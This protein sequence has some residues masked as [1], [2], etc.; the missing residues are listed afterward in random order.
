DRAPALPFERWD[1][2]GATGRTCAKADCAADWDAGASNRAMLPVPISGLYDCAN[3]GDAKAAARTNAAMS[4]FMT[5]LLGGTWGQASGV[6]GTGAA[7]RGATGV[8][9]RTAERR[10]ASE[11]TIKVS[12]SSEAV[13]RPSHWPGPMVLMC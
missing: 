12:G 1:A 10:Q 4:F 3:A 2:V 11:A 5:F 8:V 6:E 13:I 9:A 7:C